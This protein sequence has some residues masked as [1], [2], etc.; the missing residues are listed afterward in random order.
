MHYNKLIQ[1]YREAVTGFIINY[2]VLHFTLTT[3]K[4][5]IVNLHTRAEAKH[6]TYN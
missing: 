4:N 6:F 3:Q 1:I 5:I 2:T